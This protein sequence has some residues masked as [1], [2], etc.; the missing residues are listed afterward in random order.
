MSIPEEASPEEQ[1][2]MLGDMPE[3]EPIEEEIV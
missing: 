3:E 1:A 2:S